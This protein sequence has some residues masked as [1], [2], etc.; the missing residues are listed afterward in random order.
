VNDP[1]TRPQAIDIL[2]ASLD[3]HP[4]EECGVFA[5][6][7]L[8]NAAYLTFLGLYA[9]QHR[10]QEAAGICV[11]GPDGVKAHKG[12]GL[13]SEVFDADILNRLPGSVALGRSPSRPGTPKAT[14][15]WPTTET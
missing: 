5:V 9:L 4:Q 7:G 3:E 2:T 12:K 6:S 14:S 15:S 10:G 11:Y 13:V 1:Q 8:E